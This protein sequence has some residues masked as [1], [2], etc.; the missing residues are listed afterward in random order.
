MRP[1]TNEQKASIRRIEGILRDVKAAE[2]RLH[3][4]R[5][6]RDEVLRV[7]AGVIA[8]LGPKRVAKEAGALVSEGTI[9]KGAR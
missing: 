7:E 2:Y 4:A 9:R 1:L 6:V 3:V 8:E 5:A